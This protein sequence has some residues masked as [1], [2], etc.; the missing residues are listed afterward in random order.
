MRSLRISDVE[1]RRRPE[2]CDPCVTRICGTYL[3]ATDTLYHSRQLLP[4]PGLPNIPRSSGQAHSL[5]SMPQPSDNNELNTDFDLSI[6]LGCLARS[7]G[8][9]ES[10]SRPQVDVRTATINAIVTLPDAC[11]GHGPTIDP[12]LI[13]I[14]PNTSAPANTTGRSTHTSGA[15]SRIAKCG[16]RKRSAWTRFAWASREAARH[17][18]RP[19]TS[20]K[21]ALSLSVIRAPLHCRVRPDSP[22]DRCF[23]GRRT[24]ESRRAEMIVVFVRE[25]ALA[26]REHHDVVLEKSRSASNSVRSDALAPVRTSGGADPLFPSQRPNGID[27]GRPPGRDIARQKRD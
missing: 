25:L 7:V 1:R 6:F 16:I 21:H 14:H 17:G 20:E 2:R 18:S 4:R 23:A 15:M 12:D 3:L 27:P 24:T 19:S 22:R 11:I 9:D 26:C 10:D 8:T 13:R 5:C